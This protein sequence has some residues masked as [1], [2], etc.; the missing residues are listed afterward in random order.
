M[1]ESEI[2]E[3]TY[4]LGYGMDSIGRLVLAV[5]YD[6]GDNLRQFLRD[7][8]DF[9]RKMDL[10]NDRTVPELER[11]ENLADDVEGPESASLSCHASQPT[12]G[13]T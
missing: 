11:S 4:P 13:D 3:L 9:V 1:F 10:Q 2:D 5:N 12:G 7:R 8:D 6:Y